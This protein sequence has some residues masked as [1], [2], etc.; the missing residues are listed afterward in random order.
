MK[1]L[2]ELEQN[3]RRYADLLATHD[4]VR[5]TGP[6]DAGELYDLHIKD[7]LYSIALLPEEGMVIDVGSGGGLPGMVWAICRPD[8]NVTLLDSVEKKCRAMSKIAA[9]LSLNNVSVVW[10]RC[11]EHAL[12]KRESYVFA[13]AR[14]LAHAGVVAE[15][16][17]P[18]VEC[19]GRI[20]AF[21]GPK[22]VG[23]LEEIGDKWGMIGLSNPSVLAYGDEERNYFFIVWEKISPTPPLYPRRPGA[24]SGKKSWW[25]T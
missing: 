6:R 15:Y 23:E 2:E 4:A 16:L 25:A 18:L 1:N 22:G 11:E 20:T 8:L 24:A 5:L 19:G 14:G 21:K 17:S 7:S 13:A 3:L 10:A 9:V 12:M